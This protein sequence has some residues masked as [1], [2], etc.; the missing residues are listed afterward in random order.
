MEQIKFI[1]RTNKTKGN[2]RM[3]FRLVD[4]RSVYLYHK[5]SIIADLKDLEKFNEDGTLKSGVRVYNHEL[6]QHI[7]DEIRAMQSAYLLM[8]RKGSPMNSEQFE[9]FVAML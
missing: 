7:S 8:K 5:S 6:Q 9:F 3:R 2:I 4:G 1:I